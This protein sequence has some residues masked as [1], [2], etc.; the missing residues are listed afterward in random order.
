MSPNVSSD[1]EKTLNSGF[2]SQGP[3]VDD[4]EEAISKTLNLPGMPIATSS[5]TAAIDLAL[6]CIGVGPG[7]EVISTPMTCF[8]TNIGA[9]RRG[10]R[11]RWADIDPAI[12]NI[13]P[14]SVQ[15]LITPKTRAIVAVNW[16]GQFAD[17]EAL[18]SFGIPVI[19]DAA[20]TWDSYYHTI[21]RGDYIVY[22][23]QAIKFL[24][25]G[26]GGILVT[27]E[28]THQE[29]RNLRWYG[30][31]RDNRENFRNTQNITRAGFKFN[32]NDISAS[33]ALS[34]I[35]AATDSVIR[36][37][38]NAWRLT[39]GLENLDWL[40]PVPYRKSSSY[41]VFP[42]IL[43]SGM[44]R[45]HFERYLNALGIQAAQVHF[46]NDKY[47]VMKDFVEGNLPGVDYFSAYQTNIPCGWWL[48][49]DDIQHI[50]DAVTDFGVP[51]GA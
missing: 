10:A 16:A 35:P 31:D 45:D 24:T 36:H 51:G 50:I 38:D 1:L 29:A 44:D 5:A 11:I 19:E 15:E 48:G 30:L 27:P 20:H 33:I 22:S 37:R 2:V 34:N 46:R 12:G 21:E 42:L 26:D 14:F 25:A 8:A 17:Y 7:D 28:S 23:L 43:S 47:D 13:N 39:E 18:K 32:M 3:R 41:W 49:D 4:L 9:L 6:D 40:Y